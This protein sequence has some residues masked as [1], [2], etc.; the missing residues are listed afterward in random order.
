MVFL[1]FNS[2]GIPL[3]PLVVNPYLVLG[4]KKGSSIN[5]TNNKFREKLAQSKNDN[6]SKA[7]ICLAYDIIIN[8]S[9]YD[10]I[11]KDN[12][13]FKDYIY[14]SCY[15]F[16]IIGD[17]ARLNMEIEHNPKD[18]FLKDSFNR[19]LLYL[20]SRNEHT[21]LC[22]YLINKGL[23]LNEVSNDGN[24]ALHIAAFYGHYDVVK[25]LLNYGAKI[26]IK[27]NSGKLPKDLAMTKEIKDLLDYFEN[28]PIILLN[29]TLMSKNISKKLIDINY[30]GKVI[31]KK[32]L[33]TLHNL[34]EEY[35]SSNIENTW[36][37]AWHGTNFSNLESIAEIGLKPPGSL[38]KNGK[39]TKVCVSHISRDKTVDKIP[40]WA[41]GIFVS[42]S[43]FYCAEPAY[44]KEIFSQ[45]EQYKVFIEVR[46]KPFNYYQRESTCPTYVPKKGE[47][48]KVEYR[49]APENEKD[50]QVF[51]LTFVKKEFFDKAQKYI[52]AII[53]RKNE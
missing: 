2:F 17:C 48:K 23:S 12:F 41:N 27:N 18:L 14:N 53:L 32:I 10:E 4:I 15:Y 25:L 40:D 36:I 9:Y 37:T 38:L 26:N 20:A 11:E 28:D 51:S 16:T 31:A 42:P 47:P 1:T 46:V 7:K 22:E 50:V 5:E 29:K 8:N 43:I 24:T 6:K 21:K 34:P 35:K 52:D 33:C 45:N 39:E 49:I 30:N 19:N 13:E 44:A 3:V